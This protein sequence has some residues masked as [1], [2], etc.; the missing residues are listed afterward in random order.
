MVDGLHGL[1]HDAVIGS[2]HEDSQVGGLSTTSTH[3]G[4]G[5]VTRGIQEGNGAFAVHVYRGLVCTNTLGDAAF[6][7]GALV[8][9]A[10]GVQ[11]AGLTVVNVTHD[12]DDWRTILQRFLAAFVLTELQ[13]E[14]FEELAVLILRGDDLDV[15]VNLRAEQLQRIFR[16][17][18]GRRH[19]FAKV[20]QRLHQCCWIRT[21]LLSEVRKGSATTQADGLAL[22]IWQAHA[23]YDML[24]LL[25]VLMA[26]LTLR[27]LALAW[28]ATWTAE[29]TCGATATSAASAATETAW[30]AATWP[31]AAWSSVTTT[32][33]A[34]ASTTARCLRRHRCRI[35]M[36]R[37][38]RWGWTT[39]A[40]TL[41]IAALAVISALVLAAALAAVIRLVTATRALRADWTWARPVIAAARGERVIGY[42]AGTAWLRHRARHGIAWGRALARLLATS[43]AGLRRALAGFWCGRLGP[44]LRSLCAWLRCSWLCAGLRS[45]L[46]WLWCGRL[47]PRLRS[48]CAWLRC[49][50]LCPGLGRSGLRPWLR[51][52]CLGSALSSALGRLFVLLLLGGLIATGLC[53]IMSSHL[54]NHRRFDGGRS[55]LYKLTLFF[56]GGEQFLAGY[57]ELLC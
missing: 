32:A 3:G 38:H 8:G 40:A 54:L 37:H 10:D 9:L 46:T 19:H 28:S 4:K 45:A 35:R 22:A 31:T 52:T 21:D 2:N 51:S 24:L 39:T 17:R 55:S 16:Y 12:G 44:R 30:T 25:F 23:A 50:S 20:K 29:C 18:S 1:W 43:L 49:G 47:G 27:L 13:V 41:A 42:A 36:G 48:L 7:A 56:Q 15:V 57:S 53:F 33:T 34:T 11:Q 14:G 5:L 26:L 6:L